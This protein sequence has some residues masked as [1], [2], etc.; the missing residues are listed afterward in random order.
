MKSF[1]RLPRLSRLAVLLSLCLPLAPSAFAQFVKG[2]DLSWISQEESS[3][4]KFVNR[5]TGAQQD[6]FVV[7]KSEGI[8]AVRLRVWVNPSGGWCDGADTLYKAKRAKAQGAKIMIDFH[9]SDTWADP[10]K[11]TKPAAWA[12]HNLSQLNT[13]VYNHTWGILNYLK[14]NGVTAD[15]VQVGNEINSGMLWPEGSSNN[16]GNLAQLIN[17]GYNAVKAVNSGTKV[18]IH[19]ANGYDN[20]VFRWF[21]QGLKNAGA[22]YDIIGLSH[23]PSPSNWSSLNNQIRSNMSDMISRFGKGVMVCEVGMDW[24]QSATSKS[25]LVDLISKV[26]SLGSSGLGVIYWEPLAYPGWQG[27]TFGAVDNSGKPTQAMDAFL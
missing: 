25:M 27:Y 7:V 23:Y 12:N 17:S 24:Q 6:A 22:K 16:F 11:Q 8:N 26:K 21:F 5:K 19:L 1:V 15:W 13:D 2:S 9:Y 4:K 14:S 20:A 10:G 3:G 18:V